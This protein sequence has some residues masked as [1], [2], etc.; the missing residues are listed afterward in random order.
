MLTIEELRE[1]AMQEAEAEAEANQL[2][3]TRD[4]RPAAAPPAHNTPAGTAESGAAAEMQQAAELH[5]DDPADY[6]ERELYKPPDE[7]WLQK[8]QAL[9]EKLKAENAEVEKTLEEEPPADSHKTRI[10]RA[11]PDLSSGPDELPHLMAAHI[12]KAGD[13]ICP[14]GRLTVRG[15]A[16]VLVPHLVPGGG[17]AGLHATGRIIID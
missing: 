15:A 12:L 7:N 13:V 16:T 6:I 4:D 3:D 10:L 5:G 1:A 2:K 17:G 8:E 9:I 11:L 14:N